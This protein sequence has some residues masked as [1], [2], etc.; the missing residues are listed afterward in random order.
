MCRC[1]IARFDCVPH[2]MP[3]SGVYQELLDQYYDKWSRIYDTYRQGYLEPGEKKSIDV[4]AEVRTLMRDWESHIVDLRL[5]KFADVDS[6][7]ARW[8]EN[9][10][11]LAGVLHVSRHLDKAHEIPLERDE[12]EAAIELMDFFI[13]QQ[14]ALMHTT[15]EL[16]Q[17]K[18]IEMFASIINRE[19]G[20]IT[21]GK[22]KNNGHNA[23]DAPAFFRNNP[24]SFEVIEENTGKRG[25]PSIKIK[26]LKQVIA[27]EPV[28]AA[29]PPKV[30]R[31]VPQGF[32]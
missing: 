13:Q 11:R 31:I 9:T 20:E 7:A 4:P 22:L 19:G 1:L 6:F 24:K 26:A 28:N 14:L 8:I 15:R 12:E 25:R 30:I 27:A 5:G 10:W 16:E 18:K 21:L 2:V 32:K 23:D 17:T 29:E 3:D